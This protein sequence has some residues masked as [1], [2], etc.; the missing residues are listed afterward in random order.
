M[1]YTDREKYLVFNRGLSLHNATVKK[2]A[3]LKEK[4]PVTVAIEGSF[5]VIESSLN[6]TK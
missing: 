5:Y 6:Y 2:A 1:K 3:K 4:F